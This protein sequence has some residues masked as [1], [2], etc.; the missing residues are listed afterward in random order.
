MEVTVN[1]YIP[2][3]RNVTIRDTTYKVFNITEN[4]KDKK[5][6]Y[7]VLAQKHKKTKP[8]RRSFGARREVNKT[9]EEFK[10]YARQVL[11]VKNA[12]GEY[13]VNNIY[14]QVFWNLRHCYKNKWGIK[15][16]EIGDVTFK[17]INRRYDIP[18]DED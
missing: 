18:E 16:I 17:F 10:R 11:P 14:S 5:K 13:S 1:M 9:R 12:E 6:K 3:P 2:R 15:K 4:E 8:K 7:S